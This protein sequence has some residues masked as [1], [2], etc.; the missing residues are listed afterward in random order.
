MVWQAVPPVV[1]HAVCMQ[2]LSFG[3]WNLLMFFKNWQ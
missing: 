3:I 1:A 2:T